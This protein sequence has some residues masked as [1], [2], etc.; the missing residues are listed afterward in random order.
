MAWVI[1]NVATK[2]ISVVIVGGLA[3]GVWTQRAS[4]EDCAGK[5]KARAALG[6]TTDVTCKFL[7]SDINVPSAP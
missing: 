1:K 4:L 2:L 3:F 7:G 5:V 6:D